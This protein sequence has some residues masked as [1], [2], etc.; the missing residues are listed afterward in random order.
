MESN[1]NTDA[2]EWWEEPKERVAQHVQTLYSQLERQNSW[3]ASDYS[4][5][6][7]LYENRTRSS[8]VS[9][10]N[11]LP[12]YNICKSATDTLHSQIVRGQVR[13]RILTTAGNKSLRDKAKL[14]QRWVDYQFRR[15]DV[16]GEMQKVMHDAETY[17]TGAGKVYAHGTEICFER[18]YPGELLVDSGEARYGQPFQL[19][20]TK[21]VDTNQMKR[22]YPEYSR[23]IEAASG[24]NNIPDALSVEAMNDDTLSATKRVQVY[25]VWRRADREGKG[26][27]HAICIHGACLELNEYKK[28]HFPFVFINHTDRKRQ[29]WGI[30][31]VEELYGLQRQINH[32]M[33]QAY[34]ALRL[35][36]APIVF[37]NR[38]SS[39]K[40]TT[41]TNK[42]GQIF[43]YTGEKPTVYAPTP[44]SRD[45]WMQLDNAWIRGHELVGVNVGLMSGQI[46]SGLETGAA[47]R[48][49][50][51]AGAQRFAAVMQ[52]W[53]Q[54][55]LKLAEYMIELGKEISDRNPKYSVV[56]QS[57]KYTIQEVKWKKLDL[58]KDAYV[59]SVEPAS[60]LPTTPSGRIA[61]ATDLFQIGVIDRN[62][63]LRL[64]D[65]PDLDEELNLARAS[66]D[67]IDKDIEQMIDEKLQATPEPFMDL[68]LTIKKVQ[69]AYNMYRS[70]GVPDDNLEQLRV[71]MLKTKQM[72]DEAAA[73]QQMGPPPAGAP[74]EAPAPG[75]DG[76]PPTAL[77]EEGNVPV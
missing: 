38:G 56:A 20:Q 68:Q 7:R 63:Y 37:V 73:A 45:I 50:V 48:E 1:S 26:G 52:R 34:E 29:F 55:H 5:F 40:T 14:L 24:K 77:G 8:A 25:E 43:Q 60:S 28:D 13:P 33:W 2:V 30:G 62:T 71:Y 46:P 10:A 12:T 27:K 70:M 32:L 72:M 39:V 59:L 54:A 49:A 3:R 17:G 41:M 9:K 42:V 57:D 31:V 19:I 36:T 23:E 16:R 66:A 53:E 18:V 58:K 15:N 21:M 75:S 61:T 76:A 65:M 74:V 6:E 35:N 64:I 22:L 11:Y 47:V 4:N 44:V 67:T 51:D 69:T